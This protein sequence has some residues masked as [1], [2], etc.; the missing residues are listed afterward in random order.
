MECSNWHKIPNPLRSLP[1]MY[2]F[3]LPN[4]YSSFH[5][6]VPST[7]SILLSTFYNCVLIVEYLQGFSKHVQNGKCGL[8]INLRVHVHNYILERLHGSLQ[9]CLRMVNTV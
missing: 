8:I 6:L 1:N 3:P 7:S 9:M 2:S 4:T 5:F